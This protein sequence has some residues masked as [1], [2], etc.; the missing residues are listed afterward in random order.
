MPLD[1][2]ADI[3]RRAWLPCPNC[4]HGGAC[5]HCLAGRNCASHWQYLLSNQATRVSM[6][7]PGC[8]HVWTVDTRGPGR[9]RPHG[10][11]PGRGR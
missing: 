2:T 11:R 1:P 5:A 10:R 9:S 6:Q 3:G 4:D 7:C 8:T